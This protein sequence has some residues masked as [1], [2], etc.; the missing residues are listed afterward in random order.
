MTVI[1]SNEGLKGFKIKNAVQFYGKWHDSG[2]WHHEQYDFW[3]G[4]DINIYFSRV[5][6]IEINE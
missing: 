1:G 6:D 2:I 3:T 5:E 4:Q